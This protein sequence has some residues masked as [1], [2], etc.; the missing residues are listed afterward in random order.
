MLDH[1]ETVRN[2]DPI[3][4]NLINALNYPNH[5]IKCCII[6]KLDP[7]CQS[8]TKSCFKKNYFVACEATPKL[9]PS[10]VM[11][12]KFWTAVVVFTHAQNKG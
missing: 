12:G 8:K 7:V 9:K 5:Y 1:Y 10:W 4:I 2:S 6:V 3:R 11:F